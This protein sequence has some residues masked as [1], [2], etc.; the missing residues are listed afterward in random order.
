[1]KNKKAAAHGAAML[2]VFIW[3]TTFISTKLLLTDFYPIEILLL[4]FS[5]GLLA[6]L[7]A[8]PKRLKETTLKQELT[9]AAAGLCGVTLYYLLEN[10]A[11]TDTTAS[12]VGVILSALP[13]FTAILSRLF[14]PS[15]EKLSGSFFIGFA[16]AM[17]GIVLLSFGGERIELR[18]IGDLLALGAGLVW[19]AYSLLTKRIGGFGF[20]VVQTTRRVFAYGIAF[21]LPMLLFFPTRADLSRFA[22]PV[23]WLNLLFLG[24]GASALCF[25]TWGFAVNRL[26]AV[27]TS[28]Y[29][30]TVPMITVVASILVLGER[31][32]VVS[33]IGTGLTIAG[34]LISEI[35]WKRK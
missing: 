32:T 23:H 26:G 34:L 20:P 2:T 25:V 27:K 17:T 30:Y 8:Y 11:L 5:I 6:L 31:M 16:A 22:N 4:R 18:P 14:L 19:A 21:M 3:G 35:K 9:F 15:K 13:F 28:V 29:I 33:A 1:M 12:N 24:L 10:I 7:L